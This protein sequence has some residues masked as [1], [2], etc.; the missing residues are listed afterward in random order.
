MSL[1]AALLAANAKIARPD[2]R[3][4]HATRACVL[5]GG[6]SQIA[7][8]MRADPVRRLRPVDGQ[9]SPTFG[10][11]NE[12]VQML[13]KSNKRRTV[14]NTCSALTLSAAAC[15][16]GSAAD[17]HAQSSVC[18]NPNTFAQ[19]AMLALTRTNTVHMILPDGSTARRLALSGVN[20][21]L[22]GFDNR[23]GRVRQPAR[24]RAAWAA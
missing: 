11:R 4:I 23:P 18:S 7:P 22:I 9:V 13:A 16:A 19:V 20:G 8:V 15:I 1:C 5:G 2:F 14:V 3:V 24:A 17:A 6:T 10:R 12:S 21:T